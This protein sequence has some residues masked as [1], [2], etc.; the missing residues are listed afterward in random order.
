M[1]TNNLDQNSL[2]D[3][4]KALRV[5]VVTSAHGINGEVNVYPT[6]FDK[7]RF[8]SLKRVYIGKGSKVR[9]FTI[10]SV[11][12]FKNMVILG[13]AEVGDRNSSES[14]K[15][16]DI[17]I[18]RKDA[19]VLEKDEYFICDLL[20]FDVEADDGLKLGELKDIL[21]TG[22]NDVYVVLTAEGKEILIPSIRECILNTDTEAK[23]ITV[24]L[25][26]GLL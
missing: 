20:G 11:N 7:D 4:E 19:A 12:Y 22:A 8:K 25:L 15:G 6:T 21:Q 17:L 9:P 26:K 18:D 5:G 14:L 24:H 16:M 2:F 23:K 3:Y 13:F 10:S 1:E